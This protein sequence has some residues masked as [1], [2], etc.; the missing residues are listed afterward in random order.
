MSI[1][2]HI[3]PKKGKFK[4]KLS[5]GKSGKPSHVVYGLWAAVVVIMLLPDKK[6]QR[7]VEHK[8]VM[9]SYDVLMRTLGLL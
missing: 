3:V 9:K 5:E 6:R 7:D 8:D 1:H 2:K 4:V